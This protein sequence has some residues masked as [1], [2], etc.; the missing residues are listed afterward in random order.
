MKEW[1]YVYSR[2]GE[3]L[4]VPLA[5]E[6]PVDGLGDMGAASATILAGLAISYLQNKYPLHASALV[7]TASDTGE[8][9]AMLIEKI[10]G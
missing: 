3:R 8:R 7:W 10:K 4:G 6:H 5:L 2:L 1:G 9:S